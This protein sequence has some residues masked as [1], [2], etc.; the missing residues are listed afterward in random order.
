MHEI[1]S[2]N[3][4]V[5]PKA[6]LSRNCPIGKPRECCRSSG[7]AV[8]LCLATGARVLRCILQ[9][10]VYMVCHLVRDSL[11]FN[12]SFGMRNGEK[13]LIPTCKCFFYL[14]LS[15]RVRTSHSSLHPP[16]LT[17]QFNHTLG[18]NTRFQYS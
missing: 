10:Q 6:F 2:Q 5:F 17:V 8:T 13:T 14:F 7:P 11:H 15:Q 4:V 18:G 16:V 3:C 1:L 9:F 12:M